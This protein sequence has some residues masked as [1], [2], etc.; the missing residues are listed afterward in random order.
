MHTWSR[1]TENVSKVMSAHPTIIPLEFLVSHLQCCAPLELKNQRHPRKAFSK[2]MKVDGKTWNNC[3]RSAQGREQT[4][5]WQRELLAGLVTL[6]LPLWPRL[7]TSIGPLLFADQY[8]QLSF[9][10]PSANVYGLGEHVHQQY[11]HDMGWKTWPIFTRD[12]TPTKVR[13]PFS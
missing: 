4:V 7:D 5:S 13:G 6:A 8:L 10:L 9:L 11:R 3:S 12:A 1:C 2:S